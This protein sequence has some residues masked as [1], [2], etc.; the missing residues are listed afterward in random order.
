MA[1]KLKESAATAEIPKRQRLLHRPDLKTLLARA[2]TKATCNDAMARA[3]LE[4][5]YTLTE[6]GRA[7]D[8]HYAT[9]S[10]IVKAMEKTS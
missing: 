1:L 8:L 5:G 2:A 4:H 9:I 3:Y 7:T 10:R 6:I